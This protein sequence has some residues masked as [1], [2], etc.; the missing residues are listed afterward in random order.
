MKLYLLRHAQSENNVLWR[1]DDNSVGRKSDPEITETGHRQAE[2]LGQHLADPH[3]EPRQH[4][5]NPVK[6]S[7]FGLT[8]IYCSLMTRSILTAGYIAKACELELQALPDI[9]ERHGIYEFDED[10][11]KRGLPGPG[12]GYFSERFGGVNFPSGLSETGWWNQPAETEEGFQSHVKTVVANLKQRAVNGD[13]CIAMVVHGDFIDQFVNELMGVD[14][15]EHNY[16]NGWVA[17]WTFHNTSI[18]RIDF[19]ENSH[20]LVYMNRID[21]LPADAITW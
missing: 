15:H 2:F 1:G 8:H 9:F 11:N 18:T 17:N 19:L 13:E 16:A 12:L 10:G 5:F 3:G 6:S 14:R 7:H 4:P 20:T 21:H